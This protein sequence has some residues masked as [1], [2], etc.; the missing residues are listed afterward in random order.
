M[1][2]PSARAKE[3]G[4]GI[5]LHLDSAT[6]TAID[7]FSTSAFVGV[8]YPGDGDGERT[9]LVLP[10]SP[11]VIHSVTQDSVRIIAESFG[12]PVERRRVDWKNLEAFDEVLA[13]GTATAL[14]PIKSITMRSVDKRW[15]YAGSQNDRPGWVFRRLLEALRSIQTGMVEDRFGWL[16]EVPEPADVDGEVA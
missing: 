16:D 10:E 2:G 7:E 9:R 11:N 13:A 15:E 14:S 12:W 1:L 4:F 3:E 5:T 6:R 8:Q